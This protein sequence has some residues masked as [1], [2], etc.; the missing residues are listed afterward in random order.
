MAIRLNEV[1]NK[2]I[3]DYHI[4]LIAGEG[5]LRN[6]VEW[7]H[8]IE[9]E[10]VSGFLSGNE[11]V[12][13]TGIGHADNAWLSIFVPRL[14]KHGASGLVV[15]LGRHILELPE[16]IVQYCRENQFP[17][18]TIPWEVRIVDMSRYICHMIVEQ[19]QIEISVS[20]AFRN[21]IFF[22][23]QR[24]M[25]QP[26]LE[27]LGFRFTRRYCVAVAGLFG[28]GG[29]QQ[30]TELKRLLAQ[31]QRTFDPLDEKYSLL[32]QDDYLLMV[33]VDFQDA[34]L[35][36]VLETLQNDFADKALRIGVSEN[37]AD[38]EGMTKSYKQA[39]AALNI[40][41]KKNQRTVFYGDLG[42]Y[43]LLLQVEDHDSLYA[44]YYET[45]GNLDEYDRL[46]NTDYVKT[47]RCYLEQ[48]GSVQNVASDTF[49]HRNTV[50]YKLRK[51]KEITGLDLVDTQER[52]RI[53]LALKI[54]DIL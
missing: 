41:E 35:A 30:S 43:K 54:K 10:Q 8:V 2:T 45:L 44:A 9:D 16:S 14:K 22:P 1:Y 28:I 27:R 6:T 34:Q 5:G 33:F 47:L 39:L 38:M 18:F 21:A 40:A 24:E 25:Y 53:W 49:V 46:N 48:N 50:N 29:K 4:K 32:V 23:Q 12:F 7:V 11:L 52:M 20:N 36:R 19:E 13:T 17:L 15:N 3:S 42:V 51:I 26:Q 31:A 37:Q